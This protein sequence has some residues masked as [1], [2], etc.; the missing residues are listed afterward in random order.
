M[1]NKRATYIENDESDYEVERHLEDAGLYWY[2]G[3]MLT[4]GISYGFDWVSG[5]NS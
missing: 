2:D 4:A 5:V 1:K 3:Q